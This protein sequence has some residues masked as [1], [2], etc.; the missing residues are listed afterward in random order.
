MMR[1]VRT[2]VLSAAA[3]ALGACRAEGPAAAPQNEPATKNAA[4][5]A[6]PLES[7]PAPSATPSEPARSAAHPCRVQDG[8][9]VPANALRAIG[10]EPFWGARIDGRC[11]TYSTPDDQDGTR[12]WT[13]FSGSA[14]R[15]TWTGAFEGGPFELRTSPDPRCSD[16]MSDNIYPLAVTLKVIG[17]ERRGCAEPQGRQRSGGKRQ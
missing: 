3:L 5:P 1:P 12:I 2:T 16:G 10:T 4:A 15:G 14:E 9:P 6:A 17:E 8:K 11:V 7:N 13:R